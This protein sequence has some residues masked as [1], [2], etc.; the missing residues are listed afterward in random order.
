M[1]YK[2]PLPSPNPDTRIFWEQCRAHRLTFQKC[3]D[4]GHLRWPPALICPRCYSDS[5]ESIVSAGK[6]TVFTF[7]VYHQAFHPAF[8]EDLPYVVAIVKLEEGPQF[9]S[10][11]VGCEP[12]QV[13]CDLPVELVWEDITQEFSLPKFQP[14]SDSDRR[15]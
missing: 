12:D 4:C 9:V 3:N 8:K 15:Q 7:V 2:K 10:N 14:I 6:G 5:Y 1:T 11:I 13:C